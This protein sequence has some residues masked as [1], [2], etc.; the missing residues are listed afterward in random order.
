MHPLYA[1]G[2]DALV[3]K[4]RQAGLPQVWPVR[5]VGSRSGTKG[6]WEVSI[7]AVKRL[8]EEWENEQEQVW[9]T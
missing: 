4:N 5:D 2:R 6:R 8:L 9:D 1:I 3:Q 7:D